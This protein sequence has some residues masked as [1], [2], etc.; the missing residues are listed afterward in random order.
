[1]SAGQV[2][3]DAPMSEPQAATLAGDESVLVSG[4]K[5]GDYAAF[6]ELV[7]RYEKKIYRLGM[8]ITET[9]KMPKMCSRILS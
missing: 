2:E 4:A 6:E 1:M 5:A 8:N 9:P 7:N 3:Q